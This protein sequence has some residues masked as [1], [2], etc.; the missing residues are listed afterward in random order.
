MR[1]YRYYAACWGKAAETRKSQMEEDKKVFRDEK[2]S[3]GRRQDSL[4][5]G[6][7]VLS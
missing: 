1:E 3:N 7:T 4:Q 6:E 2:V 5:K